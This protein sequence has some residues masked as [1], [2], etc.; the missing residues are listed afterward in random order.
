MAYT[1]Q[2]RRNALALS[3]SLLL[4]STAVLH[5]ETAF[6]RPAAYSGSVRFSGPEG[7][8]IHAGSRV[9]IEGRG[10]GPGQKVTLT[11]GETRLSGDGLVADDEGAFRVTIEL[12]AEAALG[13]HP[14]VV[15]TDAPD[16]AGVEE[17]KVS[18]EIPLS[19]EEQFDITRVR[20]VPGLY[21]SAYSEAAGAL[22]VAA[23]TRE[24]SR[25]LK[26]DPETLD[27]LAEVDPAEAEGGA[28]RLFGVAVDDAHGNVWVTNTVN[29]SAAVYAQSDLSLVRQLPEDSVPKP[30]DVVVDA[31]RNRAY[32]S[33]PSSSTITVFDTETLEPVEA[34]EIPSALRR[35]EFRAMSLALDEAGG[36]LYAVSLGTPEV[37]R[38]DLATGEP[39]IFALPG[40]AR[41]SGVDFDPQTG[42][43]FVASQ[44]SDDVIALD[45][46]SGEVLYDTAVGAGTLNVAFDPVTGHL[47]ASNRASDTVTVLDAAS[48]EIVANLDGLSYPNHVEVGP[49]GVVWSVNKSRGP[50][51]AEGDH[52]TRIAPRD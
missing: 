38:V 52:V 43:I 33:S 3:L 28:F 8:P 2:S 46:E 6:D 24:S 16:S 15:R 29:G 51:D 5:A 1:F 47:Y 36:Q 34:I 50:G 9:T 12:P 37:A 32:L 49:D 40:T 19:G 41:A 4:A 20:L 48:G 14:V 42:R 21:Q 39:T 25:L 27:L 30:R 23:A 18:P 22:F 10:F 7:A 13:L 26:L 11:R 35:Q 45:G 17:L 31:T 44:G